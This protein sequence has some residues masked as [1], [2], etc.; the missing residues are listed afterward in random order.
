MKI[1]FSALRKTLLLTFLLSCSTVLAGEMRTVINGK[2]FHVGSKQQ[3][4]E[5]NYGLGLE[6]QLQSRPGSRWKPIFMANGFRDSNDEMSYLAGGGL[7]R[8]LLTSQQF[9]GLYIDVGVNLFMMTRKDVNDGRP[10][11]GALP[12]LSIGNRTMGINLTYL[13]RMALE[14]IT[15][16]QS[17]DK[18]IKGVVFL[19][20]KTNI[21][22]LIHSN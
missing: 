18:N 4:N 9:N 21:S 17:M 5:K 8:N 12:S 16:S 3:W 20:F 10:F 15:P 22:Q 6:Y 13:P 7:H 11:P 14:H 1:L 19:Q 2:S